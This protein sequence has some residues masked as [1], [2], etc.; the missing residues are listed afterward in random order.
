MC[1]FPYKNII[2]LFNKKLVFK[3]L[4]LSFDDFL[5]FIIR[6][7]NDSDVDVP[8]LVDGV[9]F[10]VYNENF[11]NKGDVRKVC[12]LVLFLFGVKKL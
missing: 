11:V 2:F 1:I 3:K 8:N 12:L 10:G 7:L 6:S 4:E 5:D 9:F